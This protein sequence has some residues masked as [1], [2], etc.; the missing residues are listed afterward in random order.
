M[1]CP[2]TNVISQ[3]FLTETLD[4]LNNLA[5]TLC[6]APYHGNTEA[7]RGAPQ[8]PVVETPT[9]VAMQGLIT[10]AQELVVRSSHSQ[11]FHAIDTHSLR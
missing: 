11:P 8:N 1:L 4:K 2:L 6:E 5:N 9:I 10:Y 3:E 7:L